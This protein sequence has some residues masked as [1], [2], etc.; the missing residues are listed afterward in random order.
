MKKLTNSPQS[1][2]LGQPNKQTDFLTPGDWAI[3]LKVS[4]RTIF[5]MI[6]EGIIP[7]Y[8]FAAGKIRRWREE[9]YQTWRDNKTRGN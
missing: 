4:K 2:L 1:P 3:R 9:T 7:P 5:R 6:D 8:D